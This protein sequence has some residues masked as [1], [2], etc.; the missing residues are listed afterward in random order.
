MKEKSV[1]VVQNHFD[2]QCSS[3]SGPKDWMQVLV[4]GTT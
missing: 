1:E 4:K 2:L 3:Q